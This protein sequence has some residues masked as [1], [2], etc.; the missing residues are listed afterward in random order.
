MIKKWWWFHIQKSVTLLYQHILN[1][2]TF[3]NGVVLS[4]IKHKSVT[5]AGDFDV[6]ASCKACNESAVG[7]KHR[8]TCPH[9]PLGLKFSVLEF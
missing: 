2:S 7:S 8:I 5:Q 1:G 9:L 6:V 4:E 3:I